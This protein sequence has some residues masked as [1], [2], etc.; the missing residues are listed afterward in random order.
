MEVINLSKLAKNTLTEMQKIADKHK[1]VFFGPKTLYLKADRLRI[2][3]VIANLLTN[4]ARYSPKHS[5][6]TLKVKKRGDTAIV[7]IKDQ[8]V[9]IE[10]NHQKKLFSKYYQ[11]E[12]K[13]KSEGLGLGLYISKEIIEAH[14]GNIWLKSTPSKGSTFFFSLP[15]IKQDGDET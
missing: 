7:S 6:I 15:I 10:S 5:T 1:M 8:G 11:I 4:A 12:R 13:D 9:G 3:Q 2:G 14:K